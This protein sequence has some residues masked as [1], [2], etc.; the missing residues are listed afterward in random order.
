[1]TNANTLQVNTKKLADL[2]RTW[3]ERCEEKTSVVDASD[4]LS[5]VWGLQGQALFTIMK[6]D[7]A[8]YKIYEPHE[9]RQYNAFFSPLVRAGHV[10]KARRAD[11]GPVVNS[12]GRTECDTWDLTFTMIGEKLKCILVSTST[13]LPSHERTTNEILLERMK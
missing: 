4:D 9:S 6:T 11:P 12:E 7:A 10:W 2:E 8:Q 1:M 5:G 3:K 13:C